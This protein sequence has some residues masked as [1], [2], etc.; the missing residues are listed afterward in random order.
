MAIAYSIRCAQEA[1]FREDRRGMSNDAQS[2]TAGGLELAILSDDL[3]ILLR[4]RE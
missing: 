4:H 2:R 1:A 3:F